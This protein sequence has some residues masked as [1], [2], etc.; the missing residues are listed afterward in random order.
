MSNGE[1]A[2]ALTLS[3]HTVKTHVQNLLHKLRLRNR[4]H[5]AIYAFESG[6]RAPAAP[7]ARPPPQPTPLRLT[8]PPTAAAP[9]SRTRL[10]PCRAAVLIRRTRT[11]PAPGTGPQGAGE[12]PA[13]ARRR[14]YAHGGNRGAQGYGQRGSRGLRGL[15]AGR[16][17]RLG[18]PMSSSDGASGAGGRVAGVRRRE[19]P[20]PC[21][22]WPSTPPGVV[23][24]PMASSSTPG[25]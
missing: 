11:R 20:L 4:V 23:R 17:H 2:R 25:R 1:I 14:G 24:T 3:E 7:C 12:G 10:R 21:P 8:A 15:R 22:R 5:A 9:A 6:L 16:A 13:P 18:Q 19:G